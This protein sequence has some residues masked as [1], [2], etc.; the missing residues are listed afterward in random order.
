MYVYMSIHI[1]IVKLGLGKQNI[2]LKDKKK[3]FL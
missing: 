1:Y 2:A 3:K